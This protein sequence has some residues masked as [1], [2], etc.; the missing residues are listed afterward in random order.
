M[1]HPCPARATGFSISL[2]IAALAA[3]ALPVWAGSAQWSNTPA[4]ND[5]YTPSNWTPD[6]VPNGASDTA[7]FDASSVTS[8]SVAAATQV[9][10][11]TFSSVANPYTI[12]PM[13]G[14]TLEISGTGMVNNSS[15]TQ[16]FVSASQGTGQFGTV[17]FTNG[18]SA[19]SNTVFTTQ[20]GTL[21]GMGGPAALE[22]FGTSTAGTG[23]FTN[24]GAFH[25]GVDGGET[26]FHASSTAANAA[27]T[28]N[29]A[30]V[31][32]SAAG[33]GSVEFLENSTA[34]NATFVNNPATLVAARGGLTEF[35][36]MSTAGT[37]TMLNK[38][39]ADP[40]VGSGATVFTG[41][42]SA[43]HAIVTNNGGVTEFVDA[44]TAGS[45]TL[46]AN[47]TDHTLTG[48]DIVFNDD[49][50]GG[51]AQVQVYGDGTL[52]VSTHN[53]PGL[54]IGSLEGTGQVFLGSRNLTIG[55]NNRTV[56]FLG[57]I[58]EG[59]GRLPGGTVTKIGTGGL[60]LA[61]ANT[62]PGMTTVNAGD[63]NVGGSLAGPVTINRGLL[64]GFGTVGAVTVN[65]G[66]TLS[67]G[68]DVGILTV[69]GN[70]AMNAGSTYQ[71]VL[72]GAT[73]GTYNQ[74]N[75]IGKV[76]LTKSTLAMRLEYFPS[77]GDKYI[78]IKNDGSDAVKGKFNGL[79]EG[80]KFSVDGL[81]FKISYKGGDG[82]DVVL[83]R[84]R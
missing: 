33:S 74:T 2:L 69:N 76:T 17:R 12:T 63:L 45:A 71:P 61:G 64:V 32:S 58:Q 38:G 20:S 16:R 19:G 11:I 78:I 9:N 4:S 81:H 3:A 82:N 66:G 55:S 34:G 44:A 42:S 59:G 65:N 49:S 6:H 56:D 60:A 70:L 36:H 22:F 31:S 18:A 39:A 40:N 52:E 14:V 80:A 68:E 24:N 73:V 1:L 77:V 37:A 26:A 79:N 84:T 8:I 29:P 27:F 53:A 7:T 83:T 13:E 67:P 43:D 25:D 72:F 30:A 35:S 41:N 50:S 62:Y 75:V 57:V 21:M 10:G 46:I 54:T 5:W 15:A 47:S 51:T 28:N 23:S 48:G